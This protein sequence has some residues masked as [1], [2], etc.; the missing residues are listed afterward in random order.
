MNENYPSTIKVDAPNAKTVQFVTNLDPRPS[1]IA[2][3]GVYHGHTSKKLAELLP[4]GGELHLYDYHSR[5][6][7]SENSGRPDTQTSLVMATV[8][9]FWTRTTGLS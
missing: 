9:R 1:M 8:R 4:S 5:V 2:E 7:W 3:I 6:A